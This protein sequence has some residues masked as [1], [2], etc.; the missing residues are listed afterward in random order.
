MLH[1][2]VMEVQKMVWECYNLAVLW[3]TI[4]FGAWNWKKGKNKANDVLIYLYSFVLT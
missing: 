3:S 4:S 2:E 1:A